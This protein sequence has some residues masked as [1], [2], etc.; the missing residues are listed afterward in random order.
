MVYQPVL[1][2]E[3]SGFRPVVDLASQGY[4]Y[5]RY[6]T[7]EASPLPDYRRFNPDGR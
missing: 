2:N 5:S 1:E 6:V 3:N 4:F 7:W